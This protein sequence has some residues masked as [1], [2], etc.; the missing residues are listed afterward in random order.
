MSTVDLLTKLDA[1]AENWATCHTW[2][3]WPPPLPHETLYGL[4]ATEIRRLQ[5]MLDA[6]ENWGSKESP[7]EAAV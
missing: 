2:P 6:I 1:E 3:G 7:A 5:G 4:A